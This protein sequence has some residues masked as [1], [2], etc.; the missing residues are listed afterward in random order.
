[1]KESGVM[2]PTPRTRWQEAKVFAEVN[3][4][5][6]A[7]PTPNIV[8]ELFLWFKGAKLY[9]Q[10]EMGGA[11]TNQDRQMQKHMLSTLISMGEWLVSE[12]R[13]HD[14]TEKV[15]V[16]LADVEATLEELHVSLRV[17]FGGMTEARRAQVLDEVFGAS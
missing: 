6:M 12:L 7:S 10:A 9:Y 8:E 17:S 4:R 16:T 13:H 11:L 3:A 14:I 1:M 15:G 2:G 5:D